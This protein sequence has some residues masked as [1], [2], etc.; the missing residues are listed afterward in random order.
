[1]AERARSDAEEVAEAERIR[2]YFDRDAERF[3]R[4]YAGANRSPVQGLV[5]RLFR[6]AMLRRRADAICSFVF[7]GE[8][9]LEI[10]SGSGRI[11]VP[12]ALQRNAQVIGVDLAPA[13]V[14][15]A[16]A[17]ARDAGA[18]QHCRFYQGDFMAF[19]PDRPIDV[20]VAAGV[21]DYLADPQPLLKRAAGMARRAIVVTYPH[22][23]RLLNVARWLWLYG[24]K[25][26][27]VYFYSDA[28]IERLAAAI[29]G[30]VGA[31]HKSGRWPLV[32]ETVA[33]ID[34]PAR[35]Q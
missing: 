31:R 16:E 2:A 26:C 17:L 23:H 11:A 34:L 14:E 7:E 9:C 29:G 33:R 18:D 6:S 8:T 24:I 19:V 30:R 32:E 15:R 25:R 13:M 12:L 21:V 27:P 28:D 3:D 35:S 10:G 22:K 4:I 20:V 1:M 5:D